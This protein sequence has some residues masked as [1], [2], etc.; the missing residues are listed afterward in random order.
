MSSLFTSLE[1]W[2]D[3]RLPGSLILAGKEYIDTVFTNLR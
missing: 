1:E 2:L 3:R